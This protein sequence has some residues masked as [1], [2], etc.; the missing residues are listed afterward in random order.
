MRGVW[1]KKNTVLVINP[2]SINLM[3]AIYNALATNLLDIIIVGDRKVIYDYIFER[4]QNL[5]GR[6]ILPECL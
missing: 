3:K 6:R 5:S 2:L 1:M 4:K